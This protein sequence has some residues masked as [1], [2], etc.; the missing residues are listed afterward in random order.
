M[1]SKFLPSRN[2]F[3]IV[4]ETNRK[5][6]DKRH[7]YGLLPNS[8]YKDF[9]IEEVEAGITIMICAGLDK[10]NFTDSRRLWDPIDSRPFYRVTMALNLNRLKFL[11]R[12]MRFD[13]YRNRPARQADDRLAAIR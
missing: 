4:R 5:A 3:F 9:T 8:I 13:N 10:D 1:H 12:C 11:L 7:Q 6:R 2:Y